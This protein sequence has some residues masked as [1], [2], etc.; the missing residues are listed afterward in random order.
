MQLCE[1]GSHGD[2]EILPL[3]V[4]PAILL[5]GT[6]IRVGLKLGVGIEDKV[7]LEIAVKDVAEA[8]PLQLASLV[9]AQDQARIGI[10]LRDLA[11]LLKGD[12]YFG[13][14]FPEILLDE[15]H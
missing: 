1:Q 6:Y 5:V 4:A 11:V 15:I 13:R 12:V 8:A 14:G 2:V 7:T 9:I 10:A 3:A